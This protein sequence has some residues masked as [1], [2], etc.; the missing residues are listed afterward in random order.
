MKNFIFFLILTFSNQIEIKITLPYNDTFQNYTVYNDTKLNEKFNV[1]TILNSSCE[2]Q[3]NT[4]FFYEKSSFLTTNFSIITNDT[5]NLLHN[6]ELRTNNKDIKSYY[7]LTPKHN[8]EEYELKIKSKCNNEYNIDS[9]YQLGQYYPLRTTHKEYNN[10]KNYAILKFSFIYKSNK[11]EF[12]YLKYCNSEGIYLSIISSLILFIIAL[13][14]LILSTNFQLG[15]KIIKEMNEEMNIKW[16][17]G[18]LFVILGSC[19]LLIFYFFIKYIITILNILVAIESFICL[20]FAFNFLIEKKI[21][22]NKPNLLKKN[23]IFNMKLSNILSFFFSIVLV[24]LYLYKKHWILNNIMAFG[25]VFTI[26]SIILFKSFKVC[27]FFLLFIFL[28]DTFWVFYSEKIFKG[29]VMEEVATKLNL[30]IKIEMPILFS[31]NPIKDCMLLGL[32]D[33]ALPGM[34]VK[35]CKTFDELCKKLNKKNG[36]Y[37]LSIYLYIISVSTAVI[38]VYVFEHGQPVLFYISPAFIFG[39]MGK[40]FYLNQLSDFWNG[41]ELPNNNIHEN[42]NNNESNNNIRNQELNKINE[43][44]KLEMVN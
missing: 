35:Y 9:N 18:I 27:F 43:G 6:V 8:N 31:T 34:V 38:C 33:I 32:G 41:I 16:W 2:C 37:N 26:L 5:K 22:E 4:Y 19:I 12:S 39:L 17:H 11:Y 10:N 1:E 28:Y 44:E 7:L 25:L 14:Y 13:I 30:P 23:Y 29:N 20:Q 15:Q 42:N 21:K 36:Y 24:L 40:S 3:Y